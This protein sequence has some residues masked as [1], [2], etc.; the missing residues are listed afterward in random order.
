MVESVAAPLCSQE[1][2]KKWVP[3]ILILTALIVPR[4]LAY[5]SAGGLWRDEVH[6][7]NMA[8]LP[9]DDLF[10]VLTNDSIPAC[11]QSLLRSWIA[12]FGST[13]AS[14]RVLGMLIGLATIPAM[15]WSARQF[16]VQ[17]PWWMMVLMGL[18]PSLIVYGGEVRGYGLGIFAFL[19][20]LGVSWRALQKPTVW[21]WMALIVT[22]LFA[23]QSSFTNCFLLF[24]TFVACGVVAVR[25]GRFAVCI[26]FGLIGMLAAT[27]M[28]PYALFVFPRLS[29]VIN[30]VHDPV[31]RSL[32]VKIFRQ[33]YKWGGYTR[34]LLWAAIG[35]IGFTGL[36][37][38]LFFW[39]A[40]RPEQTRE[41]QDL[42]TFLVPFFWVGTTGFWFYMY[43]LGV[44]TAPWYHLPWMTLLAVTTELSMGLWFRQQ[45]RRDSL[46]FSL[47][48][49]EQ[50]ITK[51]TIGKP[52]QEM[53]LMGL[54]LFSSAAI[55]YEVIPRVCYRLTTIDL[56]A[57]DLSE[58]V[59]PDDLVVVTPWYVGIS[60]GR[61][62]DGPA[63]WTNLP[64]VDHID[65]HLAYQEQKER[66]M[67]LP[68]ADGI[69]EELKKIEE[70]LAKGGKV[71][72]VGPLNLLPPGREPLTLAGAPDPKYGWSEAAYLTSWQQ[73]AIARMQSMGVNVDA[74]T[75]KRPRM[76]NPCE[77]PPVFV[78]EPAN[79]ET[80]A[81][82]VNPPRQL[83]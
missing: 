12:V 55:L 68:T 79:F 78:V 31:P 62:Y 3:R 2:L 53:L 39:P 45:P 37:Q 8:T 49:P 24:A 58:V 30:I 28:V 43:F 82:L 14:V 60:F 50:L 66:V 71:W 10:F 11:W 61:Y 5:S 40:K 44:Q 16:G 26:G 41:D 59:G 75:L 13:D 35:L 46:I 17:F 27:S 6:S 19:I 76:V 51:F 9:A 65:H 72:W 48:T 1:R 36:L 52:Q 63:A 33:T 47:E 67:P 7:V 15:W 74:R 4:L 32:P 42:V 73:T 57:R 54:I 69:Q 34:G 80:A 81:T 22:A 77:D 21:R 83:R 20:L 23:V 25:R 56:I 64:N 29:K 70:T 38:R 18:D